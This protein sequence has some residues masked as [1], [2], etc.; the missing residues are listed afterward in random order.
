M[1]QQQFL[2]KV[3]ELTT[4]ATKLAEIEQEL[5]G[6][7]LEIAGLQDKL[8]GYFELMKKKFE[9]KYSNN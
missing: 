9:W 8:F 1:I 7:T 5:E 3:Q 6:K 4:N 2:H